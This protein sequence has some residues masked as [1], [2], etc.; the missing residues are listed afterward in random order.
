MRRVV[1]AV[2]RRLVRTLYLEEDYKHSGRMETVAD[3][4]AAL[5]LRQIFTG[6][7]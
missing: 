2:Y 6:R 5:F 3:A 7:M 4:A 1:S